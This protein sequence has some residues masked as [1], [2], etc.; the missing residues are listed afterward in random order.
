[1]AID[2]VTQSAA[3]K[4]YGIAQ[5]TTF[6]TAVIDAGAFSQLLCEHTEVNRDIKVDDNPSAYGSRSRRESSVIVHYKRAMPTFTLTGFANKATLAHFLY[7]SIQAVTEGAA[8]IYPKTFVFGATQ[9]DFIG[10]AGWFGTFVEWDPVAASSTKVVD[11]I[12]KTL[13]LSIKPGERLKYTA[14]CVG[15]GLASVAA[16]PS[17]TWTLEDEDDSFWFEDIDRA[18]IDFSGGNVSFHLS[19]F[20]LKITYGDVEAI[21]Q[22][23]TGSFTGYGLGD[24]KVESKIVV[25]KDADFQTALTNF[26]SNTPVDF[27]IGWGN[28][29]PGTVD[30]DLDFVGHGK[31][32]GTAKAHEAVMKG[33]INLELL[34]H[35]DGETTEALTVVLGNSVL[36]SW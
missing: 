21:G 36:R 23:G 18:T 26:S 17:G 9:P 32:I 5:E 25:V 28:A 35:D 20:E 33:E 12:V 34:E 6:G 3:E 13:T 15:R 8:A 11:F 27:N 4:Q 1:M 31:I 29:T 30:G 16:D 19:E 2:A 10:S 22:D 7:G 14:E 24:L